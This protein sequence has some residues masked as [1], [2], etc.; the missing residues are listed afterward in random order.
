MPSNERRQAAICN[1][2]GASVELC[3][4]CDDESCFAAI[5]YPCLRIALGQSL[6][7]PH[8]MGDERNGPTER[9]SISAQAHRDARRVDLRVRRSRRPAGRSSP[10]E[11]EVPE[12]LNLLHPPGARVLLLPRKRLSSSSSSE[13]AAKAGHGPV[14]PGACRR[15]AASMDLRS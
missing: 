5:C 12:Q 14:A 10:D 6:P 9:K 8:R 4:F 15:I 13:R 3:A 2:C 7:Q 1:E 11:A